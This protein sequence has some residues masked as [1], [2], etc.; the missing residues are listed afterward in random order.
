MILSPQNIWDYAMVTPARLSI[1]VILVAYLTSPVHARQAPASP[2]TADT[3]NPD[4]EGIYHSGKDVTAAKLVYSVEPEF[5]EPARKRNITGP[6]TIQCVVEA[7]GSVRNI[8]VIKSAAAGYTKN[9]DVAAAV[10]LD[11]KAIETVSKYRFEPA[12]FH[13]KP[14]PSKITVE[15]VFGI[16]GFL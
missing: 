9:K 7:D 2:S 3:P 15:I 12:T 6:V 4:A 14:V 16:G 1:A 11:Q 13:G 5:S 8:R 10:T